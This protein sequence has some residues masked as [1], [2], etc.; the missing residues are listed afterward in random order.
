MPARL[1]SL[2]G[3]PNIPLVAVLTV[4][5]RDRDCDARVSSSR[6]SRRHCC[7]GLDQDAL[8]VRDLSSTNGTYINGDRVVDGQLRPG[9]EL[10]IAHLRYR[11]EFTGDAALE[12]TAVSPAGSSRETVPDPLLGG[13]DG[14]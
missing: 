11:F 9:D 6:V 7:L 14:P 4:V 8:I 12:D 10:M 5:G 2:S 13:S 1:I 3:Y